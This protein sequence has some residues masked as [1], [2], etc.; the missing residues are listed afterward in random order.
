MEIY[1]LYFTLLPSVEEPLHSF[2]VP[3]DIRDDQIA[4]HGQFGQGNSSSQTRG[5]CKS[6]L[7]QRSFD[8]M[9]LSEVRSRAA[10]GCR[11]FGVLRLDLFG[12]T[13][14]GTNGVSSDMDFIV[15]FHDETP[16]GYAKRFFGL[17]RF[18][19]KEF[20]CRVDLLTENGLKNPYLKRSIARDRTTVY[21]G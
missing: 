7:F 11:Q 19:E 16:K 5:T 3:A 17:Q 18:L 1:A 10:D 8:Q 12:S 4:F 6:R 2:E 21:E 9:N 13:A 20:G 15:R 14:R